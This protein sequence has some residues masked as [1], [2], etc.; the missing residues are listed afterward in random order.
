MYAI[1]DACGRQYKVREGEIIFI[2]RL[3]DSEGSQVIFDK[4]VA[5]SGDEGS[6][7]GTPYIDGAQVTA[8]V[9]KHG[10]DSKIII[11]KYKAKKTYRKKQGHRQPNTKIQIESIKA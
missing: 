2:E 9:L 7:F 5:L 3:T 8:K 10:K 11:Y 6:Q 4:I 1:I